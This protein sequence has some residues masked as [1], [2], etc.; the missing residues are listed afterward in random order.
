MAA[1]PPLPRA[2]GGE[3]DP[4]PVEETV[5]DDEPLML[6]AG[7]EPAPDVYEETAEEEGGDDVLYRIV[8]EGETLEAA[9]SRIEKLDDY[10]RIIGTSAGQALLE[11]LGDGRGAEIP[12]AADG[13]A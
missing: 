4:E 5:E 12:F 1:V 13:A 6:E 9:L 11:A 8:R 7:P 10:N 3:A 2:L